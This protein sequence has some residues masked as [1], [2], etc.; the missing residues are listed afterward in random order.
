MRLR[1]RRAAPVRPHE[2]LTA[3]GRRALERAREEAVALGHGYLGSEHLLLALATDRRSAAGRLLDGLGAGEARLREN[4]RRTGDGPRPALDR[5]ALATIGIDLDEVRRRIEEAFGAGALERAEARRRLSRRACDPGA[6]PVSPLLK[7]ALDTAVRDS[8]SL[9]N[10]FAG[11][12][13]LVA[14]MCAVEESAAARM[15]RD[16]GIDPGGA[17]ASVL[18]GLRSAGRRCSFCDAPETGGCRLIAGPLVHICDRCVGRAG[19]PEAVDP[20]RPA[21]LDPAAATGCSFCGSP[22]ACVQLAPL[23]GPAGICGACLSLCREIL[24][25]PGEGPAG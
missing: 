7:R 15:L 18:E 12:E 24:V 2:Q 19:A 22:R 14:G 23:P 8:A 5:D 13:H 20:A 16:C 21:A 10:R 17:R 3:E 11:G 1:V 4:A 6:M 25:E 9:G